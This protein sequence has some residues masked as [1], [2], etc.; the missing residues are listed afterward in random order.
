MS[1]ERPLLGLVMIV[2]NEARSIKETF[3]APKT[4]GYPHMG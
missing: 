4:H 2:K 1:E 3:V